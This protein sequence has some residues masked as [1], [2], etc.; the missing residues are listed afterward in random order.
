MRV[1]DGQRLIFSSTAALC[2]TPL[3]ENFDEDHP[4]YPINAYGRSKMT[5]EE[6]HCDA[7]RKRVGSRGMY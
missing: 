2:K 5:A 7:A 3:K 4:C 6:I 1:G